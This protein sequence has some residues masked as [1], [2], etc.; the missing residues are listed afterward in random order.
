MSTKIRL[1]VC[2]LA[3]VLAVN[4]VPALAQQAKDEK[5]KGLPEFKLPP[6]WTMEDMQACILAGTPGKMHQHLAEGIGNWTGKQTMWMAPGAEPVKSELTSKCEPLMDGRFVKVEIK[7]EMPGMGPYNGFGIYGY[8]NVSQQFVSTWIDNHSTGIMNGTGKLSSDG[9]TL[10]TTYNHIC[11]IT[12]KP[13]VMRDIETITGSN[14]K[15]I[16]M[17]GTDPKSGK[18]YKMMVLE[19]TRK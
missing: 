1:I 5:A 13:T 8:D 12:K 17:H 15:T 4:A 9:K 6:G 2:T 3:I 7:G 14:T 18:E 10:T 16:E 19:L 11:P